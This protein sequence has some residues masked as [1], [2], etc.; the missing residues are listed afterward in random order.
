MYYFK[1]SN[2]HCTCTDTLYTFSERL[3]H[4]HTRLPITVSFILYRIPLQNSSDIKSNIVVHVARQ[5]TCIYYFKCSKF[6]CTCTDTFSSFSDRHIVPQS[7]LLPSVF[8]YRMPLQNSPDTKTMHQFKV[9]DQIRLFTILNVQ[10]VIVCALTH[11]LGFRKELYIVTQGCLLPLVFY[12]MPL[13]NS[14]YIKSNI[15][16]QGDGQNTFIYYF[17]CL[18]RQCTCSDTLHTFSER[19]VHCHTRLPITVSVTEKF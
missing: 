8:L 4:C 17:K 12:S 2:C 9:S 7:C 16:V 13:Q 18:I 5:N 15:V 10:S 3:V 1:C 11:C 6:H 19:H 14:P